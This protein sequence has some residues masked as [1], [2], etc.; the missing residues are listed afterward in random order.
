MSSKGSVVMMSFHLLLHSSETFKIRTKENPWT[1]QGSV[2]TMPWRRIANNHQI[3]LL[4]ELGMP[5]RTILWSAVFLNNVQK[6]VVGKAMFI[7]HAEFVKAYGNGINSET[8]FY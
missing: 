4:H 7:K 8:I 3:P 6:E 1:S 5:A 2:C